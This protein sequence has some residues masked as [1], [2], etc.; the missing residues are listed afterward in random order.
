M[1]LV[2]G[3]FL[4]VAL[5]VL[6]PSVDAHKAKILEDYKI[7]VG[8]KKE[9]PIQGKENSVELV[10]ELASSYDK[11]KLDAIEGDLVGE[12]KV[13]S[14]NDISNLEDKLEV[15]IQIAGKK[16]NLNLIEDSETAGL[17]HAEF[18]PMDS[19]RPTI[20]VFGVINFL[21]FAASFSPE[22]IEENPDM[23]KTEVTEEPTVEVSK[24]L[25]TESTAIPS[26]IKN[27]AAWWSE[28][29]IDDETFIS[30]IQFLIKNDI[31]KV[32]KTKS[33]QSDSKEIPSWIKNNAGWWASDQI[34]DDDFLKGIQ[35]LVENGI[36][37][38]SESKTILA[39]LIEE[40]YFPIYQFHFTPNSPDCPDYHLHASSGH[41][42]DSE[43]ISFTDP[44]P[45]T[46]G[47][48]MKSELVEHEVSVS[49]NQITK[50]QQTT[51]II[52]PE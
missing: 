3:I 5:F 45:G 18:T 37:N 47:F 2:F 52:I 27:N 50:W 6:I 30:G 4:L 46:C 44:H 43:L 12:P 35:F 7:D 1:K 10:I 48:G 49:E 34:T 36:I 29:Q 15:T 21:E 26:W 16:T 39:Y 19:G 28:G 32:E 13:P 41:T 17:Y 38:V 51:G 8:W 22:K 42:I 24:E 33:I 40:N 31:L 14:N 11:R 9:P 25:T 23:P 20:T